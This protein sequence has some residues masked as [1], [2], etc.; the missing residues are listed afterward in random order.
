MA[1]LGRLSGRRGRAVIN[2]RLAAQGVATVVVLAFLYAAVLLWEQKHYFEE[3]TPVHADIP[4]IARSPLIFHSNSYRHNQS[5]KC[6]RDVSPILF[7][8]WR[9]S[10]E[11]IC[12]SN[13]VSIEQLKLGR[14]EY[15][16]TITVFKNIILNHLFDDVNKTNVSCEVFASNSLKNDAG[17]TTMNGPVFRVMLFDASNPY[18]GFHG[19]LN[20]AMV[21]ATLNITNPQLVYMVS[22]GEM[23][24]NTRF[25]SIVE[26]LTAFSSLK[27]IIVELPSSWRL[28]DNGTAVLNTDQPMITLPYMVDFPF[29]GTSIM[30]TKT[31]KALRGRGIDHHCKS[32]IFRGATDFIRT[33]LGI[34]D[35]STDASDVNSTIQVLWSS[36]GPYCCR[37]AGTIYTPTRAI[38]NEQKLVEAVQTSLGSHYNITTVDFGANMTIIDSVEAAF[39]SDIIVGVHGAGL[40][41]SAFMKQHSGLVEMFGG[42]RGTANRHYHNIASLTDIHY[43]S[44]MLERGKVENLSWNE[45]SLDQIVRKIQSINLKEEPS[46]N[47]P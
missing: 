16:P 47:E 21:M 12:T 2:G 27:P 42:N 11:V 28:T 45:E 40:V 19:V 30:V 38:D 9:R 15:K 22:K 25:P 36:R 43:R 3:E 17:I 13:E 20:I 35:D 32:E 41:W 1:D 31:D 14:W 46:A 34:G 37:A 44:L 26:M 10:K 4:I 29:Q 24:S 33:N 23:E 5:E 7:D 18:E 6:S 39:K 8:E